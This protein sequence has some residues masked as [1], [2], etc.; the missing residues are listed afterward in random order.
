MAFRIVCLAGDCA[1]LRH[2]WRESVERRATCG[3]KAIREGVPSARSLLALLG[4]KVK[5]ARGL[6][7]I[8]PGA[9]SGVEPHQGSGLA[10]ELAN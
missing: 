10:L 9:R 2:K 4:V 5:W 1:S 7:G 3:V 8:E 6:G